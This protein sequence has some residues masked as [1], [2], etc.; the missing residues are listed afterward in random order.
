L[1]AGFAFSPVDAGRGVYSDTNGL[2]GR[3][4]WLGARRP[5][6]IRLPVSNVGSP[7]WS[8]DGKWIAIDGVPRSA[9]P[10]SPLR[11]DTPWVLY[12]LRKDG[13]ALQ[14]LV[15]DLVSNAPSAW[16]P[17]GRWL[18]FTSRRKGSALGI[19]LFD[20]QS[21]KPPQL[22]VEGE[23]FG[24]PAWLPNGRLVVPVGGPSYIALGYR[25]PVGLYIVR[26][27]KSLA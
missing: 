21:R 4:N 16:S 2:R 23:Q 24:A 9:G 26:L 1:A 20:L 12:R 3:L 14:P 25:G 8:P 10:D 22:L 11:Q 19:W 7:S 5:V 13:R 27:P 18:A 6:P 17:D 15:S